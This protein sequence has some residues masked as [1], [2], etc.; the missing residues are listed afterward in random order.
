MTE[1]TKPIPL[2]RE[3]I[4]ELLDGVNDAIARAKLLNDTRALVDLLQLKLTITFQV[5]P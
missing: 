2:Q 1:T 5:N 3:L 4:G